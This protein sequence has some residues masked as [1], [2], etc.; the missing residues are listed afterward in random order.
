L[1]LSDAVAYG[2]APLG[3]RYQA[4]TRRGAGEWEPET[5][6]YSG[7]IEDVTRRLCEAI[8]HCPGVRYHSAEAYRHAINWTGRIRDAYEARAQRLAMDCVERFGALGG[9]GHE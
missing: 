9:D 8:S 4:V 3:D 1:G 7:K 2:V 5:S 6:V